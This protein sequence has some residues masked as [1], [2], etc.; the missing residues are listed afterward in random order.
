VVVGRQWDLDSLQQVLRFWRVALFWDGEGLV[1][2]G[3]ERME[4]AQGAGLGGGMLE[5][6]NVG[7]LECWNV[8]WDEK[9][10]G[11]LRTDE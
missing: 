9:V 5:C 11:A 4:L 10:S 6:W 3:G 8:A 2:R 7:M 1:A